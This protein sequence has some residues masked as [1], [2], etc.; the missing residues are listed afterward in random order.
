VGYEGDIALEY[1]LHSPGP[2]EGLKRF[3]DD[4]AAMF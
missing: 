3:Y 2:E 4:F 1:E